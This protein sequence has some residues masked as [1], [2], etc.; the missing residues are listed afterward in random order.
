MVLM[1]SI[2]FCGWLR[3]C[4]IHGYTDRDT[5]ICILNSY[6][7]KTVGTDSALGDGV[8]LR[9]MTF[10]TTVELDPHEKLIVG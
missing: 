10:V 4:F 6:R 1:A 2:S 7:V 3:L 8:H 9:W 5:P